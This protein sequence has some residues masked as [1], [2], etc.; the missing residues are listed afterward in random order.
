MKKSTYIFVLL[1]LTVNFF[2]IQP[3]GSWLSASGGT[4]GLIMLYL[5]VFIG[6]IF[7]SKRSLHDLSTLKN[8]ASTMWIFA[9]L[10]L[11]MIPAYL[12]SQQS[13]GV[14]LV[15]YR[16]FYFWIAI[17]MLLYI[18]PNEPDIIKPL[19]WFGIL[20]FAMSLLKSRFFPQWFFFSETVQIKMS[21]AV[22]N[23]LLHFYGLAL[24]LYPLY[25]YCGK[26]KD[27]YSVKDT[28]MVLLFLT[29]LYFLQ[30]RST[31]FIA[32]IITGY[33]F[34][35]SKNKF[36]IPIIILLSIFIFYQTQEVWMELREQTF[37]QL[38]DPDYNRVKAFNYF[39]YGANKNLL[40]ILL[41]NG[42]LSAHATSRMMDNM[43]MGIF[44]SDLGMIGFWNQ[45]GIIP[46]IVILV[47]IIKVLVSKAC[48]FYVK[49][50]ALHILGG[51]LTISYF[52]HPADML[53]FIFLYYLFLYYTN[54]H[55]VTQ[56]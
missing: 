27:K 56:L 46:I 55:R 33:A 43:E 26:L 38:S 19:T 34:L 53:W 9:G 29:F 22:E 39:V 23:E 12:Y 1:L 6:F 20:F 45:F 3:F 18:R 31:L 7:F 24:L 49:A 2:D 5:W 25:Y 17:P 30:N 44:N 32:V 50:I 4:V 47:V 37:A 11:S 51:A 21:Y 36:G 16:R 40:T 35:T 14:S 28:L 48:P 15:A 52:A 54:I 10:L 42:Y 8:N 41:G 13:L